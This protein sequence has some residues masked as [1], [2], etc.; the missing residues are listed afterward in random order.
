MTVTALDVVLRISDSSE[1]LALPM[2][3]RPPLLDAIATLSRA[4]AVSVWS[5]PCT[6]FSFL[7]SSPPTTFKVIPVAKHLEALQLCGFPEVWAIFSLQRTKNGLHDAHQLCAELVASAQTPELDANDAA[8]PAP[9]PDMDLILVSLPEDALPSP[10]TPSSRDLTERERLLQ[11]GKSRWLCLRALERKNERK[12]GRR[13]RRREEEEGKKR[14]EGE[15]EGE[16]EGEGEK[17]QT[18]G[19]KKNDRSDFGLVLNRILFLSAFPEW[20]DSGLY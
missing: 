15:R 12:K 17:E 8:E 13:R 4:H 16:G 3:I 9:E 1:P 14:Q 2:V 20:C 7:I 11:Q 19:V 6:F 18:N 5:A 10:T